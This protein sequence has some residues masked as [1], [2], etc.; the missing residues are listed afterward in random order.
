MRI[1]ASIRLGLAVF[2]CSVGVLQSIHAEAPIRGVV[3]GGRIWRLIDDVSR[4]MVHEKRLDRDTDI[5]NRDVW[6]SSDILVE[7][8]IG[9]AGVLHLGHNMGLHIQNGVFIRHRSHI[10][11]ENA[12][13]NIG[14]LAS[15]YPASTGHVLGRETDRPEM[16]I[17]DTAVVLYHSG[18]GAEGWIELF[19]AFTRRVFHFKHS[20]AIQL[21]GG[22]YLG[23]KFLNDNDLSNMSNDMAHI[24]INRLLFSRFC[25]GASLDATIISYAQSR[26][27]FFDYGRSRVSFVFDVGR[28]RKSD[29][30]VYEGSANIL[31]A[32]KMQ[33]CSILCEFDF[34]HR[35]S[36][37]RLFSVFVGSRVDVCVGHTL[38]SK[39]IKTPSAWRSI[40]SREEIR[41]GISV[42][43]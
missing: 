36:A 26:R 18:A 34:G 7:E 31:Y 29:R 40:I 42:T 16:I 14:M 41:I 1:Y 25:I 9:Y 4:N 23:S 8:Q 15:L 11:F 5:Y 21:S 12:Y 38:I 27:K 33:I 20:L 30:C 10:F 2:L 13:M 35:L 19:P 32:P 37:G 24:Y 39:D 43:I 28:V 3:C 6:C 22:I 17:G